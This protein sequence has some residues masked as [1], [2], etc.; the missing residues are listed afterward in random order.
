MLGQEEILYDKIEQLK[1][2]DTNDIRDDT[3]DETNT[4]DRRENWRLSLDR[5]YT[6]LLF[7]SE[8]SLVSTVLL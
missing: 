8:W 2:Q 1:S 3:K 6:L 4:K 7:Q 5:E